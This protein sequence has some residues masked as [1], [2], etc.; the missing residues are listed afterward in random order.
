MAIEIEK[1][2]RLTRE[3]WDQVAASL[4][5]FRSEYLGEDFEENILFS[6]DQVSEK[7]AIVRIRKATSKSTI[8]FKQ[9][10][11]ANSDAKH[12]LEYESEIS[13]PDSVQAILE[14]IGLRAAAVYEKKRKTYKFRASEVMLDELPFGLFMEIEGSVT[15][16]AEA[17]ML[18]GIEDLA[19]EHETY[20]RM[21]ARFG[22]LNGRVVEAR[23]KPVN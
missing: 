6:N 5:E 19:V 17:E 13:D 10:T 11:Q 9:R 2:Y 4:A 18:L 12:Q 22:V 8:T 21:T 16:I 14:N 3:L 1:K 20:P 23:F 7:K 15:A